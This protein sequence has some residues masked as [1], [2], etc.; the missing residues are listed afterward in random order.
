MPEI[1]YDGL[2]SAKRYA[3]HTSESRLLESLV[4]AVERGE[5]LPFE[6]EMEWVICD[7]CR[8]NGFHSHRFGAMSTD[9]LLAHGDEFS[10]NYAQGAFDA[11]CEYCDGSGKLHRLN[12]SALPAQVQDY[13]A[14]YRHA[15]SELASERYH[16]QRMGC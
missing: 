11:R 6:F 9:E 10:L 12:E 5:L 2:L 7:T 4:D 14:E 3:L 15:A 13:I 1:D 16:E 8:G